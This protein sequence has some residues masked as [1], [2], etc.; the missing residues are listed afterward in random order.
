MGRYDEALADFN[1][2]HRIG[3]WLCL[4]LWRGLGVEQAVRVVASSGSHPESRY[5]IGLVAGTL[6]PV[7]QRDRKAR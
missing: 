3:R 7:A 5:D 6:E 2:S 1:R 4:P